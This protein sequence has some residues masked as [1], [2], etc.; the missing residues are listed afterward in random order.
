MGD[1]A[2]DE[3]GNHVEVR[4]RLSTDPVD[5]ELP[6]GTPIVVVPAGH[7]AHDDG[8][9]AGIQPALR[10]GRLHGL[11][12][13]GAA[14]GVRLEG[15]RHRGGGRCAAPAALPGGEVSGSRVEI[16]MLGG[17]LVARAEEP[18]RRSRRAGVRRDGVIRVAGV[19][20]ARIGRCWDRA[21]R[22]CGRP[23]TWRSSTST[24][25]STSAPTRCRGHPATWRAPAR[26]ACTSPTS[27]TTPRGRPATWRSTCASWGSR[28]TTPTS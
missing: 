27:P 16:E 15:R 9:D 24:A 28:S 7:P 4:G 14:A 6:S 8:D 18:A 19:R 20:S 10:L 26:P 11:E 23:T 5:R 3:G 21:S 13:G 1:S 17:R 25:S 12:R 2:A 22:R